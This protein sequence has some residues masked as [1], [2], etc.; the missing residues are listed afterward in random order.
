MKYFLEFTSLLLIL[1]QAAL[2]STQCPFSRSHTLSQS[3]SQPSPLSVLTLDVL[4]G[5]TLIEN[6][7]EAGG[8]VRLVNYDEVR[9]DLRAVMRDSQEV[10]MSTPT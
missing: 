3:R 5:R 4:D 9:V 8:K 6:Y 10:G 1:S 2:S 7:Q